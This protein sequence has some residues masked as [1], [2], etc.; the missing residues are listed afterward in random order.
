MKII[1]PFILV[2]AVMFFTGLIFPEATD[3][4]VYKFMILGII[5][6]AVGYAEARFTN[7]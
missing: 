4:Q 7:P 5:A 1:I 6:Y 2:A 3:T